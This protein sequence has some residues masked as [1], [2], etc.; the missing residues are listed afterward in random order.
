MA[1]DRFSKQAKGYKKFRPH[2]PEEL[3][4][5]LFSRLKCFDAAWDVATGNGQVAERLAQ[6]FHRVEASDIAQ[7]QLD[8]A[9]PHPKIHYFLGSAEN[10]QLAG[11]SMD[12]ITVAQ[13]FH[14]FNHKAFLAEALRVLKP[15]GLMAIWVYQLFQGTPEFNAEMQGIYAHELEPYWDEERKLLEESFASIPFP[16]GTEKHAFSFEVNWD[17][18]SV[19]TGTPQGEPPLMK[20]QC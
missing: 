5:F 10:S 12:L 11:E 1:K 17:W 9:N 14:W 7:A 3:Y 18:E 15:D 8:Q 4:A 6:K 13:A 16:K 19:G 20:R 2:Y